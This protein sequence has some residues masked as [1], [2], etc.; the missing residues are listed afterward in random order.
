MCDAVV[1]WLLDGDPSVRF[2]TERDLRGRLRPKL[3]GRIAEEGWGHRFLAARQPEGYWGRGFYQP[4]WTSSH[5][6][7][8]DLRTLEPAPDLLPAQEEIRRIVTE[9]KEF[10]GGINLAASVANSDVCVNGMF[11]SYAAYFGEKEDHLSSVVDFILSQQMEDG[12]FNCRKNRSGARHSSLHSTISVL[13]GLLEYRTAGYRYRTDQVDSVFP[14]AEE[15]ILE[16]SLYKSDRTGKTIHP[17]MLTLSFPP[18]WKYNILRALDYF[19]RAGRGWDE[20]M[21]DAVFEL[22]RKRKKDG[23]WPLQAAHPGAVHFMMEEPRGPSRWNSL[24]ALRVLTHYG[25][26]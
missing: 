5:Y 22:L 24:L 10:D 26:I 3:Q 23:R 12:G 15:F 25:A 17:S 4:K 18:R 14:R 8:L 9:H 16:H 21:T 19:R 20:R 13:E 6:T 1:D 11:L 7:L 2:Q